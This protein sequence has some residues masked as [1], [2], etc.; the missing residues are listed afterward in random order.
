MRALGAR[1]WMEAELAWRGEQCD[2]A[3]LRLIP[4]PSGGDPA[5]PLGQIGGG[6]RVPCRA[7]GFPF[8]QSKEQGA[9]RDT[10]DLAGE[11]APLTGRESGLLTVHVAGSV[12]AADSSGH[13][14]WE[15]MSGAALF[16]GPLI[17]GVIVIDPARFGTDRLEAIPS[18]RWWRSPAFARCLSAIA[19]QALASGGR[20][21]GCDAWVAAR[22]V[23]AV[24]VQGDAAA[25]R[26]GGSSF[27]LAAEYGIVPFHGRRENLEELG[28]WCEGESG[29]EIALVH[30]PGGTGKTR[31]AAELCRHA[32]TRG[33]LAGF[34][35]SNP[36]GE[37]LAAL[38]DVTAPLVIVVDEAPGRLD[39]VATLLIQ[40][41]GAPNDNR[42][43]VVLL[44]RHV[45]E[46]WDAVLPRRL[47]DLDAKWAYSEASVHWLSPVDDTV[48][49]REQAF[50][51][52]A[53]AF[54]VRMSRDATQLPRPDLA[55]QVFEQI[56][57]IHLA[58]LSALTGERATPKGAVLRDDLLTVAREREALY[59]ADTLRG[60]EL[61]LGAVV[62]ERA[63][64]VAT[65]TFAR[66]EDQAARALAAVPDLRDAP[67]QRLR[68]VARW[69]R[70]ALSGRSARSLG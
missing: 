5:G 43:R 34:L 38:A 37:R 11:I 67:E 7:L 33:A 50:D 58:A 45:G 41:A 22:P 68:E 24:A 14:P 48:A 10:E 51:A 32:Q 20:R 44:A 29:L 19:G 57:F 42:L 40:L 46:W 4:A 26:R 39:D 60:G 65:L 55:E 15:G 3:L 6:D 53:A 23:P 13:S 17:V 47:S 54:A 31:L 66:S 9:V 61:Q 52:A 16:S 12:P 59:W 25:L 2:A 70:R 35:E 30:G 49:E 63:V 36:L 18:P 56:L 1:E 62:Q 28:R 27:L 64:T 8:A 69:L 21:C